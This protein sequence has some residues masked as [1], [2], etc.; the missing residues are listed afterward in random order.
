VT[1]TVGDLPD[2][3]S[4]ED[5]GPG[6]APDEREHVFEGGYSTKA[7]GTGFGLAIVDEIADAHGWEV[8][9]TDGVDGG[10]RFEI[11]GVDIVARNTV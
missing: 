3:F 9:V 4:V 5:D 6:I 1:I 7:N 10:A 11:T 2:G 8:T